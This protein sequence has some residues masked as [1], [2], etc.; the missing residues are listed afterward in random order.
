MTTVKVISVD[1]VDEC[2]CIQV[3]DL[4]ELA[5]YDEARMPC[6]LFK[7]GLTKGLTYCMNIEQLEVIEI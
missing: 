2:R 4:G 6:I 1:A 7:T 5:Y 3:G